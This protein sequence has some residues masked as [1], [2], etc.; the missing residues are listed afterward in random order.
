MNLKKALRWIVRRDTEASGTLLGG[1]LNRLDDA[2]AVILGVQYGLATGITAL[3]ALH[4]IKCIAGYIDLRWARAT[5]YR[6][7][8]ISEK[9]PNNVRILRKK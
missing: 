6:N 7:H 1:W 3:F 5:K 4:G 2:V 9:A 8:Y